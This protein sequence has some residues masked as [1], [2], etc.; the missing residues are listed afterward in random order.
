MALGTPSWLTKYRGELALVLLAIVLGNIT[1]EIGYRA[2][3]YVTLPDRL[4]AT[5]AEHSPIAPNAATNYIFDPRTGYRYPS[6]FEAR[7]GP[8]WFSHWRTNSHGHVSRFEYPQRKPAGEYRIAV[9]GDSFTANI[10]NNVRWTELLEAHLN[11]SAEWKASVDGRFTRVINFAVDGMGL[12]NFSAM[13]RHH[14]PAFE[15]DLIIVNFVTDDILRRLRYMNFPDRTADRD[16]RIRAYVK[17]NYLD[18][19]GWFRLY[20]ELF[21]AT[22]GHL[23]GMKPRLPLDHL[24]LLAEDP[25]FKFDTRAEAIRASATAAR[26][27]LAAFPNILFLRAPMFHELDGWTM[28]QWDGLVQQFHTA[29]PELPIVPMQPR[30]EALLEG[31]RLKDRPDL[32][33]L[34][35]QQMWALPDEHRLE[36]YR[37]FFPADFHPTDY[38]TTLYA[39]EVA[40]FLIERSADHRASGS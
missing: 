39:N 32:A 18:R 25:A 33:G 14:V 17:A 30:M 12:I 10:T 3:K 15:P 36:L 4:F 34:S 29:V 16:D 37:W 27:M 2:Y 8:P 11:A 23:F 24:T 26:E 19:I 13:I 35:W 9:V 21:A 7:R 6:N 1:F 31:K 28:P 20:P 40:R 38:G 22:I 5:V